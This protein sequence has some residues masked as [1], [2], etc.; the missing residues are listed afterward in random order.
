M[1]IIQ[2]NFI[3]YP[4]GT[5]FDL[6]ARTTRLCKG[7]KFQSAVIH[8]M[9]LCCKNPSDSVES[10]H[11]SIY[12]IGGKGW[13]S[14]NLVFRIR[15]TFAISIGAAGIE[16]GC[17]PQCYG[18]TI[19]EVRDIVLK[20]VWCSQWKLPMEFSKGMMVNG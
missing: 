16:R 7:F 8:Q 1:K 2:S 4:L 18:L 12:R 5:L 9:T 6:S 11:I 3:Y 15:E 20:A 10:L 19:W 14:L 17:F 13:L